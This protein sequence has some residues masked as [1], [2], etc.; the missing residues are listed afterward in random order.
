MSSVVTSR[1]MFARL[2]AVSWTSSVLV[3]SSIATLPRSESDDQRALPPPPA[4]QRRRARPAFGVVDL[5]ELRAQRLERLQRLAAPASSACS[6]AAISSAGATMMTLP[7]RRMSRPLVVMHDVERLIPRHVLQAQRDA[8]LDGVADRRCSSL[9]KSAISCRD[10]ARLDVLEVQREPLAG[11]LRDSGRTA[12]PSLRAAAPG[13]G[14]LEREEVVGLVR[15]L[16]VLGCRRD[17]QAV[18]RGSTRSASTV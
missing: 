12:G 3:R 2:L 6:R 9:L 13:G 5:N 18:R 16:V 14:E 1:R 11:V 8:A 7:L 10:G 17:D 4:D 15:H